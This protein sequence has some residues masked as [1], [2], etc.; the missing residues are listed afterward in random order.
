MRR[1]RRRVR[2]IARGRIG[3]AVTG[4]TGQARSPPAR[5][6]ARHR[7]RMREAGVELQWRVAG[8]VAVLAARVL[9]YLLHGTEGGG[10]L[11]TIWGAGAAV[12]A[13]S[14]CHGVGD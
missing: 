3:F 5:G 6:T 13:Q 1:P 11:A 14:Y 7:H 8:D 12:G 10:R 4:R 9:E 2:T